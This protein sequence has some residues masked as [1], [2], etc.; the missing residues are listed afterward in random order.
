MTLNDLIQNLKSEL[1]TVKN[2]SDLNSLNLKYILGKN[3]H[4]NE[5]SKELAKLTGEE[6]AQ[7]GK[8]FNIIKLEL[9][10]LITQ[11]ENNLLS[12]EDEQEEF[13]DVTLPVKT[14]RIGHYSPLTVT[15]KKILEY[16][17]Y[18]GYSVAEGPDIE[19]DDFDF[20]RTNLPKDH[21]S[22]DLQDVIYL[23]SPEVLLRTHTSSVETRILSTK[24]PPLRFVVPGVSY[25]NETLGAANHSVFYQL[26]GV[27]LDKNISM[28]NLKNTLEDFAKFM[29]G[30][31]I[32][33]RFRTKHYPE[34]EPGGGMDIFCP[35]CNGAG[36]GICK[37]RGWM[38]IL[39]CGM[40]HRNT[41]QK[42]GVDFNEYSGFAFGMG[43]DKLV[44]LSTGID[45]IRKLR[46]GQ[47]VYEN[48]I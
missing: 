4:L 46:G 43:L 2:L 47:L 3:S 14:V 36:C 5:A 37:G 11:K 38:E 31:N 12:N 18:N 9:I 42:C 28:A 10:N 40:I 6:K 22:R 48:T 29:Y 19:T 15:L 30:E 35:F 45:D 39:G 20:E 7:F 23:E 1:S 34:V 32:K 27:C 21:P 41:L 44:M 24:K 8:E 33:T 25:R 26:Q 16:F 13:F 17:T